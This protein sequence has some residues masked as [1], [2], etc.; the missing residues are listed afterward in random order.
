MNYGPFQKIIEKKSD[1]I[2]SSLFDEKRE[3]YWPIAYLRVLLPGIA[4]IFFY[5]ALTP[6]TWNV[7]DGIIKFLSFFRFVS[8]IGFIIFSIY[9]SLISVCIYEVKRT[10]W[11]SQ[12]IDASKDKENEAVVEEVEINFDR[13]RPEDEEEE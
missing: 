11:K 4:A 3:F 9:T 6:Y 1:S 10:G 2:R 13:K 5:V 7:S 8:L 12:K